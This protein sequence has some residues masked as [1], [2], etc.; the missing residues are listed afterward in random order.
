MR[1]D[2]DSSCKLNRRRFIQGALGGGAALFLPGNV[3]LGA[4]KKTD[5]WVFH[6]EN[7]AELMKACLK[8]IFENGGFGKDVKKLTLKV[9]AAW[10]R[11][12]KQ[13]ANTHPELVD[14]FLKGCK[15]HGIKELVMP[16]HPCSRAKDSF[17]KS[18]L[19]DAAKANGV[20]MIDLKANKDMFKE[21][22][23][24]KGKRLKEA[25]VG[26]H[27][28]ETDALVNMPVAKHHSL[29]YLTCAMKNWMGAVWDRGYWHRNNLH[30]CI[31]DFSTF[32]KPTWN[33]V[34]ATRVML[35]RGPQGPTKNMKVPNLLILAKDPVAADAYASMLMPPKMREKMKYIDM[36]RDMKV[37]TTDIEQM[38][39]HKV[40]VS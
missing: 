11:T 40:E 16:E 27:F 25:R 37:G 1:S 38:S 2:C 5:L 18:G 33:V 21:V 3:V 6:G 19:L 39:V 14:A 34:D 26:R 28:L 30:Q 20:K 22:K 31:A 24:S 15:Q 12:P 7:K 17:P 8:V 9:N 10:V 23:I 4:G 32:I 35:D 13:G 36:A 29:A